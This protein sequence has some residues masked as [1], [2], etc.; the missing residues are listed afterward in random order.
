MLWTNW[1]WKVH[2]LLTHQLFLAPHRLSYLTWLHDS[3]CVVGIGTHFY[4]R[5]LCFFCSSW[6]IGFFVRFLVYLLSY[7][8][9]GP[10]NR[11]KHGSVKKAPRA[12]SFPVALRSSPCFL[13]LWFHLVSNIVTMLLNKILQSMKQ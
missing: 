10:W 11:K 3:A 12:T 4:G 7:H 2:S 5:F 6:T 13:F 9:N 1:A 8:L